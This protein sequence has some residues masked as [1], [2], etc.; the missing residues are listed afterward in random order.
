MSI[1][2][3]L[4]RFLEFDLG[5]KPPRITAVRFHRR[6]E[7]RQIVLDLDISFDGPIEVE[8]ALFKRFLKLGANHAE[9]RGTA[10]V[11]LGPLLDE[12]PLFGA[13]TWYLPDRPVS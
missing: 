9:L 4:F 10:R 7:N 3:R 2:L 6:T 13:V 1:F 5:E 11:I 12:I 8:V